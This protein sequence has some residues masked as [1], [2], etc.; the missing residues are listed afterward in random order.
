MTRIR[1]PGLARLGSSL[2]GSRLEADAIPLEDIKGVWPTRERAGL[3]TKGTG[4]EQWLNPVRYSTYLLLLL[5]ACLYFTQHY[6]PSVMRG[7]GVD[8]NYVVGELQG[9]AGRQIAFLVLGFVGVLGVY[10]GYKEKRGAVPWNARMIVPIALLLGWCFLSLFWSDIWMIAA[11]R[12]F[13][14]GLMFLGGFG[15]ALSWT[16][17][18]VLKFIALSS[19]I[20]L[21]IG[22]FDEVMG[23]YFVPLSGVYRFTGTLTPN[24]EGYLCMVLVISSVCVARMLSRRRSSSLLYRCLACYGLVFMLLTRSRGALT[25][26]AVACFLYFFVVLDI[27]RKVLTTLL[28]GTAGLVLTA[29]GVL[30]VIADALNRGGEGAESF[31][32]RVPL[33]TELMGYVQERPW[34][35]Y[36]YESFWTV[37][38]IDDIFKHQHWATNSAHSEYIE[39]MLTIGMIGMVLHTG[40]L[41]MGV[42]EG[43]RLF[44]STQDL[45]CYL[46]ASLCGIYLVGGYLEALL[47]VKPSIVSFYLAL[48]LCLLMVSGKAAQVPVPGRAAA[49]P[50][51]LGRKFA[52][53]ERRERLPF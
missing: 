15:L 46:A 44:R 23:G 51:P 40:A 21:S 45:A 31:T 9:N 47:I 28:L 8:A 37:A 52:I 38:T 20:N 30:P 27:R 49:R 10:S 35:G 50:L 2:A 26:L 33:W 24:E 22:F 41:L 18:E 39:S 3:L 5:T 1:R 16:S 25:A 19:A 36:G 12:L 4:A 17:V 48:L 42:L 29:T 7:G 34:L 6:P 13:V 14:V 53:G 43:T 11:K 32:G